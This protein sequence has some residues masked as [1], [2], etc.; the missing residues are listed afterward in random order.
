MW[1]VVLQVSSEKLPVLPMSLLD[2]SN[3]VPLTMR[4]IVVC[5]NY[6]TYESLSRRAGRAS[7]RTPQCM[8]Y[9]HSRALKGV[10]H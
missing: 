10:N 3:P 1:M 2:G 7:A 6:V 4:R 9:D 5:E 8:F